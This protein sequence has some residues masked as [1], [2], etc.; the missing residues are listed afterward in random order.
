MYDGTS[1]RSE[2]TGLDR[3]DTVRYRQQ[4]P[5]FGAA[6]AR[7][8][9]TPC[10]KWL[11]IVN[12]L[13]FLITVAVGTGP[14][15]DLFGFSPSR[16][17][18]RPWGMLTYMFLHANL[19]H[20]LMNLLFVFFFGP[21]LE[22]RWGSDLFIKFYLVCGLGGVLLSFAFSE[23]VIVGASAACY[24]LVLA[25]AMIWPNTPVYIW[26]LVPVRVKWIAIFLV[27]LSFASAIGPGRDGIAHLAHL[28]GAVAAFLMM[29]SGRLPAFA[30]GTAGTAAGSDWGPGAGGK[31]VR[32]HKGGRKRDRWWGRTSGPAGSRSRKGRDRGWRVQSGGGA[33]AKGSVD[34]PAPGRREASRERAELDQVDAVLDKISAKGINELTAEERDLL[35]RVSRQTR[36]N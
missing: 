13:V 34:K 6:T 15:F 25:F 2:K 30:A 7:L 33:S 12:A 14:M 4:P 17:W 1:S 19:W 29:K 11:L 5:A 32:A 8:R 20:L 23:A 35:D 24:G 21:S 16:I 28:G 26:G 27:A 31:G 36:A 18:V 10:V 3:S 22:S 9:V